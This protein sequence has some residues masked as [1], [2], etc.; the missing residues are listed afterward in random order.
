MERCGKENHIHLGPHDSKWSTFMPYVWS[1]CLNSSVWTNARQQLTNPGCSVPSSK[2]DPRCESVFSLK[3]EEKRH[4]HEFYC[5]VCTNF[6]LIKTPE[7]DKSSLTYYSSCFQILA[8]PRARTI[9]YL[10]CTTSK[11]F[12][13]WYSGTHINSPP[14]HLVHDILH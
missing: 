4:L 1:F 6:P 10:K 13:L 5:K 9:I 8:T 3:L 11:D 2:P 14:G 12:T 7:F